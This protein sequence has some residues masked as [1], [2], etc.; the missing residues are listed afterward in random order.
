MLLVGHIPN[1]EDI[2]FLRQYTEQSDYLDFLF[3]ADTFN[4]SKIKS[5]DYMW[6]NFI[7]NDDFRKRILQHKAEFWS[8]D[9]EKRIKLGFGSDF[10]NRVAYKYLFN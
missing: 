5:A 2:E 1:L 10:E 7:N 8:E 6:C 4:Y 9:D 3:N